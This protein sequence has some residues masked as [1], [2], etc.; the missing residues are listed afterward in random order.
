[1]KIYGKPIK[2]KKGFTLIELLIVIAILAILALLG[3]PRLAQ[4]R[5]DAQ[6]SEI[7]STGEVIGRAAEAYL[8]AHQS[9][10]D[11]DGAETVAY[12]NGETGARVTGGE[13]T[14]SGSQTGGVTVTYAGGEVTLPSGNTIYSSSN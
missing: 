7:Q 4:F 5:T 11:V 9:D 1:M 8:A 12:L 14:V 10:T 13:F 6:I 3:L 2:N